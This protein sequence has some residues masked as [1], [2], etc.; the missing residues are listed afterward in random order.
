MH[1]LQFQ[2]HFQVFQTYGATGFV[3]T[4]Q[5]LPFVMVF[6]KIRFKKTLRQSEVLC[7]Q[8]HLLNHLQLPSVLTLDHYSHDHLYFLSFYELHS[9]KRTFG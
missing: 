5:F 6:G 4:E 1:H 3:L 8:P 2:T 7:S 9:S